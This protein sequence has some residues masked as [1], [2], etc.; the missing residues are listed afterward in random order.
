MDGVAQSQPITPMQQFRR[1][2]YIAWIRPVTEAIARPLHRMT[3]WADEP[4]TAPRFWG[5]LCGGLT[6][7]CW[8]HLCGSDLLRSF[9]IG[10]IYWWPSYANRT[11][12]NGR[13]PTAGGG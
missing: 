2:I 1:R 3:K 4:N 5:N 11:L 7:A 10:C 8:A 12:F 6:N 13:R 9:R